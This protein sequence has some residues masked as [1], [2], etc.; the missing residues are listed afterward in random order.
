MTAI[1]PGGSL[2]HRD[3]IALRRPRIRS[4]TNP[5]VL[6]DGGAGLGDQWV[7]WPSAGLS[8]VFTHCQLPSG[9]ALIADY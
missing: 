8:G 9:I 2:C 1:L 6:L 7:Q 5:I 4:A 3:P